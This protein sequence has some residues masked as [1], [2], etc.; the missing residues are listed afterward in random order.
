MTQLNI[1]APTG[2]NNLKEDESIQLFPNPATNELNIA[3]GGTPIEQVK[4]FSADGKLMTDIKQSFSH[5]DI[6]QFAK[7]VY[8]AEVRIKN[9]VKKIRWVKM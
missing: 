4:I 6:S 9:A 2:I 1:Q 5:I 8:V 3:T 7:G